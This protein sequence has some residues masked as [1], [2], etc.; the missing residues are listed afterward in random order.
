[1]RWCILRRQQPTHS[2]PCQ[3]GAGTSSPDTSRQRC[4]PV[5]QQNW[6]VVQHCRRKMIQHPGEVMLLVAGPSQAGCG[7]VQGWRHRRGYALLLPHLQPHRRNNAA[8]LALPLPCTADELGLS[9]QEICEMVDRNESELVTGVEDEFFDPDAD[10]WVGARSCGNS[11]RA[12]H[13][14]V[15]CGAVPCCDVMSVA[16]LP[17]QGPSR[18]AVLCAM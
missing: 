10:W 16:N 1:M 12:S 8:G 2:P 15:P 17:F 14:A 6:V 18:H 4:T 7:D 11:E 5:Q 9:R 3:V 13:R